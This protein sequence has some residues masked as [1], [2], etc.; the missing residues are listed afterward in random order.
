MY[1]TTF[2]Q[3]RYKSCYSIYQRINQCCRTSCCACFHRP[4]LSY[5]YLIF[6][7]KSD[8]LALFIVLYTNTQNFSIFAGKQQIMRANHEQD[9]NIGIFFSSLCRWCV[10][11]ENKFSNLRHQLPASRTTQQQSQS[12]SMSHGP[13]QKQCWRLLQNNMALLQ[14]KL[15]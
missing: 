10:S 14:T 1:S 7:L 9:R 6:L 2:V 5:N 15:P 11:S 4:I 12:C 13:V 8:K 3:C